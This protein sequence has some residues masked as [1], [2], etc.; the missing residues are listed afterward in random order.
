MYKI[1]WRPIACGL[2]LLGLLWISLPYSS[3]ETNETHQHNNVENYYSVNNCQTLICKICGFRIPAYGNHTFQAINCYETQ[4]IYCGTVKE[5][6]YH[7]KMCK[8]ANQCLAC[9]QTVRT[10]FGTNHA[11]ERISDS[12]SCFQQDRCILCGETEYQE[13]RYSHIWSSDNCKNGVWCQKCGTRKD[14]T[15]EHT[16]SACLAGAVTCCIYCPF[17]ELSLPATDWFLVTAW[18]LGIGWVILAFL[19]T[20]RSRG[21]FSL[22][23]SIL[24]GFR[25]DRE[26]HQ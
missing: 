9:G 20:Y 23:R 3:H 21:T 24:S 19:Y 5:E 18:L 11:W 16:L 1:S 22:N 13:H 10:A 4:C 17:W 12:D 2:I 26:S 7:S 8:T 14:T 15:A 25:L 6:E